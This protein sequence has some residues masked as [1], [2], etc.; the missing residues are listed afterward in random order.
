MNPLEFLKSVQ[1][2]DAEPS[3]H[4]IEQLLLITFV[5]DV[6]ETMTHA[7]RR[8]WIRQALRVAYGHGFARGEESLRRKMRFFGW[9]PFGWRR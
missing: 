4:D 9:R 2:G 1:L 3:A 7:E 5:D 6:P 8:E